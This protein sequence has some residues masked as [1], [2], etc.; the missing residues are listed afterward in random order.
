MLVRQL[1]GAITITNY[2]GT[3]FCIQFPLNLRE[4]EPKTSVATRIPEQ[5]TISRW[6]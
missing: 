2:D 5:T 4:Q 3:H 6:A 1:K